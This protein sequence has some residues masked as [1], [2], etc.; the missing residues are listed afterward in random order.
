[1]HYNWGF[2]RIKS[3]SINTLRIDASIKGLGH[4][5]AENVVMQAIATLCGK[6]LFPA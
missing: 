1:M 5:N 4:E 2:G 6:S 3:T